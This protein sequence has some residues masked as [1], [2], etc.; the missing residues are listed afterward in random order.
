MYTAKHGQI[1]HGTIIIRRGEEKRRKGKMKVLTNPIVKWNE[2][3]VGEA[4]QVLLNSLFSLLSHCRAQLK[5]EIIDLRKTFVSSPENPFFTCN[6]VRFPW[7]RA[8]WIESAA[9]RFH[10]PLDWIYMHVRVGK[11]KKTWRNE[12]DFVMVDWIWEIWQ[13]SLVCWCVEFGKS[14]MDK[15]LTSGL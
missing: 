11:E 3:W 13:D 7:E 14:I 10:T 8:M 1:C 4:H 12:C 6:A 5:S 2:N 15:H 9:R